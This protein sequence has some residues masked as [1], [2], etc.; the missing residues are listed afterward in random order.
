MSLPHLAFGSE[1]V[2]SDDSD[3][4]DFNLF[5]KNRVVKVFHML[6]PCYVMC[7]LYWHHNFHHY[8]PHD[9]SIKLDFRDSQM[10]RL[11]QKM[12]Y[13][14]AKAIHVLTDHYR[15]FT[16]IWTFIVTLPLLA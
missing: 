6:A 4:F 13:D 2:N 8:S 16:S 11:P 10:H 1:L 5:S 12:K 15:M 3:R 7:G 14:A 9:I